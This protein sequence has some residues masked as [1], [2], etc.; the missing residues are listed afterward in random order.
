LKLNL[1]EIFFLRFLQRSSIQAKWSFN[2]T[3]TM[4]TIFVGSRST[5]SSAGLPDFIWY[6]IPKGAKIYQ[7]TTKYTYQRDIVLPDD[8]KIYQMAIEY[9]DIFHSKSLQNMP[10]LGFWYENRCTIWQH[11]SSAIFSLLSRAAI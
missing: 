5:K 3:R 10:E 11:W 9:A 8:I 7:R 4:F 1:D 6:N 2:H